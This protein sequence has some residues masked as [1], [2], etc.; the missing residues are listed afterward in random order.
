[1]QGV[2]I[3]DRISLTFDDMPRDRIIATVARMPSDIEEGLGPQIEDYVARWLEI[4]PDGDTRAA[5]S[6]VLL[7]TN[8]R[9]SLDGRFVTIRKIHLL[10][11]RF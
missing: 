5:I 8:G 1:M 7:M 4:R 10:C 3:G 2:F 6:N 9:Y 11:E